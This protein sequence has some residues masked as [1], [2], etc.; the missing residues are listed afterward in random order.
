MTWAPQGC[1]VAAH[2]S[3][4]CI[5][6][7]QQT[8]TSAIALKWYFSIGLEMDK[9]AGHISCEMPSQYNGAV[10]QGNVND[11]H[12]C[13]IEHGTQVLRCQ[14]TIITQTVSWPACA[15]TR[16]GPQRIFLASGG[17]VQ[18]L[19]EDL[20]ILANIYIC[21]RH[22]NTGVRSGALVCPPV[23]TSFSHVQYTTGRETQPDMLCGSS[24][25]A[26]AWV[27]RKRSRKSRELSRWV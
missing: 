22:S 8:V 9:R 17:S 3:S 20:G 18:T 10:F 26:N 27:H 15:Q 16:E 24:C 13:L 14:K 5:R 6:A 11:L 1:G 25:A 7:C 4:C 21:L 2:A 19:T 23:V 12:L